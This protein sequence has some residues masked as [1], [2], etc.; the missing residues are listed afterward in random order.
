LLA[1]G[2][3]RSDVTAP[4]ASIGSQFER[5]QQSA[6]LDMSGAQRRDD[7]TGDETLEELKEKL[8]RGTQ[9]L[10]DFKAKKAKGLV[11]GSKVGVDPRLGFAFYTEKI[12]NEATEA[13]KKGKLLDFFVNRSDQLA[14]ELND[15]K[16]TTYSRASAEVAK[17]FEKYA[18]VAQNFDRLVEDPQKKEKYGDE[19]DRFLGSH[20]GVVD[21]FLCKIVEKMDGVPARN[22]LVEVMGEGEGFNPGEGF[23]V[24]IAMEE[25]KETGVKT[26]RMRLQYERK[27][28]DKERQGEETYVFDRVVPPEILQEIIKEGK[29]EAAEK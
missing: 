16:S 23:E 4:A 17:V 3:N 1:K 10:E 9:S 25:D 22:K 14:E 29:A 13:S 2:K 15:K 20:A 26:P 19:L 28:Y 18:K 11:I 7:V 12:K 27:Y 6:A 24:D 8:D 5:A 21:S